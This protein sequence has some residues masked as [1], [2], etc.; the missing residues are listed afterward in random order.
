MWGYQRNLEQAL[1]TVYDEVRTAFDH[2]GTSIEALKKLNENRYDWIVHQ[3]NT[4]GAAIEARWAL[5]S[6]DQQRVKDAVNLL[7]AQN[8][9]LY[10]AAERSHQD[11]QRQLAMTK[12]DVQIQTLATQ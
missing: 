2:A 9:D 7:N 6:D 1:C 12:H 11:L 4:F 8:R 10:T 5:Q 3:R